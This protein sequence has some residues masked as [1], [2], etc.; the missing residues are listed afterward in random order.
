MFE[1]LK[2]YNS[3]QLAHSCICVSAEEG[4]KSFPIYS[5]ILTLFLQHL[6]VWELNK[7]AM[8][9]FKKIQFFIWYCKSRI[10]ED[11]I[12]EVQVPINEN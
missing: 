6:F 8:R 7:L 1:A 9:R 2:F 10:R 4:Q 11:G 3:K 12:Y 5:S